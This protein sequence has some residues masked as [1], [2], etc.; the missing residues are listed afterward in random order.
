LPIKRCMP[1][2][3]YASLI[4]ISFPADRDLAAIAQVQ[5]WPL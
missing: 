3:S 5:R 2:S 1:S 4:P